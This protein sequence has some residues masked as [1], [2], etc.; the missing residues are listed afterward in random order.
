MPLDI[1][2]AKTQWWSE[3]K[4]RL[5][6]AKEAPEL[7]RDVWFLIKIEGVM[8]VQVPSYSIGNSKIFSWIGEL[9]LWPA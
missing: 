6:F 3:K 5:S 7:P 8:I 1:P 4:K 9:S 2:P